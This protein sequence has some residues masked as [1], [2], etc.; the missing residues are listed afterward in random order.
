MKKGKICKDHKEAPKISLIPTEK[1]EAAKFNAYFTELFTTL[2]ILQNR[3]DYL[4]T[5]M[6]NYLQ[7]LTENNLYYSKMFLEFLFLKSAVEKDTSNLVV[8]LK[9]INFQSFAKV[10]RNLNFVDE[11]KKKFL[12][13]AIT[14]IK[15]GNSFGRYF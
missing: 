1:K 9:M 13:E 3:R 4:I 10:F 11:Y 14:A 7:K 15:G 12:I 2:H 5:A 8:L 6:L